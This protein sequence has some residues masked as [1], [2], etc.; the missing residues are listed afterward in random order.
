MGKT[1]KNRREQFVGDGDE[2]RKAAGKSRNRFVKIKR[3]YWTAGAE[4]RQFRLQ[5]FPL[6]FPAS[7]V[8]I[9]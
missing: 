1:G 7:V 8:G 2:G 3:N 5:Y 4:K 9:F 6:P